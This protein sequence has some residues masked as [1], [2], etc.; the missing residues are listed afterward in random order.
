MEKGKVILSIIGGIIATFCHKYGIMIAL[1]LFAIV[2]DVLT[3]IIK[4]NMNGGLSSKV[5]KKGF[6][7]KVA[8]MVA[9]FFGFFLDYAI[10]YMC[11]SLAIKIPFD[12]PFGLIICF[13]IVL[14]EGISVIENLNA[15]GVGLP[16][17][18]LKF[19]QSAQK[20]IEEGNEHESNEEE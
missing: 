3:G 14:N 5:G 16:K 8:E 2:F 17:W 18:I 9:L 10:P 12:T 4:A 6:W 20:Q 15:C 11:A 13:Y 19:L 1:V 7:G